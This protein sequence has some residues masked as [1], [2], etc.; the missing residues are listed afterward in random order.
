MTDFYLDENVADALAAELRALGHSVL[1]ARRVRPK[2]TSDHL[3]PASAVRLR[4]FLITHDA[5]DYLLLHRAF[6]DWFRDFSEPPVPIQ[7]GILVIEQPPVLEIRSAARL[8]DSFVRASPA[9]EGLAGRYVRWRATSGWR[10]DPDPS[11][12]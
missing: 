10:D 8:I 4:R 9:V 3:Q 2:G 11:S 7:P 12:G 6:R 1:E 5:G